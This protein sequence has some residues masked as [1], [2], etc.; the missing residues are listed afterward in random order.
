MGLRTY[1][2]KKS[3]KSS[4]EHWNRDLEA[5]ENRMEKTLKE[6]KVDIY[7]GEEKFLNK[8]EFQV[9]EKVIHGEYIIIATGTRPSSSEEIS[10]DG[11]KIITHKEAIDLDYDLKSIIILGGNVE[12]VEFGAFL[13]EMG[14]DVTIIEKEDTIL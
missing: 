9:G 4:L 3:T 11:K 7:Y 5:I 8:N 10:L 12:G 13:G 14:I 1:V 6:N 2:L